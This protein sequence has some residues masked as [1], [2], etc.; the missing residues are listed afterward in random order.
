MS[1]KSVVLS[2]HP[3]SYY[4]LD[5]LTTAD[6]LLSFTDLLAQYSSYQDVLDNFSS[7]SNIYGDVIYDYSGLNNNG[8]YI[9]DP[10]SH[11]LPIVV[12]NSRSTKITSS[13]STT[14]TL[15]YDYAGNQ[16]TDHFA[17]E[18]S[19]DAEFTLECWLYPK[20]S[21]SNVV[22]IF[23]DNSN[24]I[25]LF[26]DKGNITFKLDSKSVSCTAPNID[27]VMHIVAVY[28]VN[29][30]Y[31]YIN[32]NLETSVSLTDF[33]F[34]NS[35]CNLQSG[36]APAGDYFLINSL[37]TY[38]YALSY[39]QIISHYNEAQGLTPIQ[40]VHPENGELFRVYDNS[41]TLIYK[42]S[43]PGNKNWDYFT[44]TDLSYNQNEKS[45]SIAYV[46][47]GGSKTVVIDDFIS[48]P[49]SGTMDSSKIEWLA[50]S[51]VTVSISLDGTT[52]TSCTNGG[53]I[54]GYEIGN[55]SSAGQLYIR[56][57]MTTTD[58]S[59]YLPK[60]KN[61]II[62]FYNNQ[63]LYAENS[64][65]YIT[66]LE[67]VSGV[68]EFDISYPNEYSEVLWRSSK[69]G[70]KT[71]QDSGFMLNTNNPVGTLQFF[72]T[73]SS[74]NDN[75][76]INISATN[77]YSAANLYWHN[78]GAVSKTNILKIYVNGVDKTSQT[79][80]SNIFKAGDLHHVLIVFSSLVSGQIK[81]GNS[82]YGS[83]PGL[84][85]N[86]A[87]YPAQFDA[88]KAQDIYNLYI[89]KDYEIYNASPSSSVSM[90][91]NSVSY[92]DTDW[93]VVQTA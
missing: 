76:L 55:F 47:A 44:T 36:P 45:M 6:N 84:F 65:S 21:S 91:E 87:L 1:Y 34:T 58:A 82:A 33:A 66:T 64:S 4:P 10:E 37:A 39:N 22:P 25:G 29:A 24:N 5:D 83:V 14:Y 35:Q 38:R 74:L 61:L 19:S 43:Y 49:V 52:Y 86:I 62:S 42:Y 18:Y 2:D 23:A 11:I 50:S 60:I 78:S 56:I 15:G 30:A 20:I 59:K 89:Y 92:Y 53:V 41:P 12:G 93:L 32:G 17:T 73:P 77:G 46:S 81:F 75:G 67:G 80:V 63:L 13:N 68:S 8:N 40:I 85:Q 28:A 9:G 70:I 27:T 3:L 72:Y 54:P 57:T 71:I 48:I 31:I 7:Y 26:Y 88:T 90:T 69:N 51:G 16:Y 79:N